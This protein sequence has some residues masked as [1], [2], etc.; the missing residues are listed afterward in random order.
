MGRHT[1]ILLK[2]IVKHYT[3]GYKCENK[4]IITRTR[5]K[6]SYYRGIYELCFNNTLVWFYIFLLG[7]LCWKV[8]YFVTLVLCHIHIID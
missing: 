8:D 7:T 6:P 3:K 1:I 2:E 4:N 5:N